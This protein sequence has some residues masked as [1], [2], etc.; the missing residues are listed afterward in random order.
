MVTFVWL[1]ESGA[2]PGSVVTQTF[3]V[4]GR[5][6]PHVPLSSTQGGAQGRN[7]A[8]KGNGCSVVAER[9]ILV[10][11]FFNYSSQTTVR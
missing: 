2:Q 6:L 8:E 10:V 4:S 11:Y 1:G 3:Q 7:R 9:C 5:R